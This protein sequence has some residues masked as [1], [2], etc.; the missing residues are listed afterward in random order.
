MSR[1]LEL[2]A[3]RLGQDHHADPAFA[4]IASRHLGG[5]RLLRGRLPRRR[6]AGKDGEHER[7]QDEAR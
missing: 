2:G 3:G 6:C 4:K 5:R 1:D 7:E